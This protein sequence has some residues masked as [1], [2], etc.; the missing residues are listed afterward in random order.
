MFSQI[1]KLS[2]KTRATSFFIS[3]DISSILTAEALSISYRLMNFFRSFA[4]LARRSASAQQQKS[5]EE[6]LFNRTSAQERKYSAKIPN[7]YNST[8]YTQQY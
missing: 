2:L 4:K 3:H 7:R 6:K 1:N 5:F 8:S